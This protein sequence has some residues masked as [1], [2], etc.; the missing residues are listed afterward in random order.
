M[1]ILSTLT[2]FA[3]FAT[4]FLAVATPAEARVDPCDKYSVC[5]IAIVE[6]DRVCA[7]LGL[8]MQGVA[9]CATTDPCAVV[10]VGFNREEVCAPFA[11]QTAAV[12]PC[13]KYSVCPIVIVENDRICAGLALGFQGA[14]ACANASGCATVYYGFNQERVCTKTVGSAVDALVVLP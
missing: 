5:P 10:Y 14:A 3:L 7:G 11:I 2:L 1:R 12:D 13:A 4:A 6:D 8:G 9:A